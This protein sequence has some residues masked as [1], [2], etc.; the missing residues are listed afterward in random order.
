MPGFLNA[1]T[2]E[3]SFA[4]PRPVSSCNAGSL[5][6]L[7]F[8]PPSLSLSFSLSHCLSLSLTVYL[9]VFVSGLCLCVCLSQNTHTLIPYPSP[10]FL[11]Y[12][13]PFLFPN[14]LILH[15]NLLNQPSHPY[16]NPHSFLTK[17]SFPPLLPSSC[18]SSYSLPVQSVQ[19]PCNCISLDILFFIATFFHCYTIMS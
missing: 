6:P 17:L 12:F 1:H 15:T 8:P 16:T 19:P 11:L 10:F 5:G 4:N 14:P 3:P 18:S 2:H 9:S 13:F 7:P